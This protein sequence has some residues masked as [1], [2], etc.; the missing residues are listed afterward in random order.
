MTKK[1]SESKTNKSK[2]PKGKIAVT[3]GIADNEFKV[4][5]DKNM[6]A[7]FNVILACE[8]F[9]EGAIIEFYGAEGVGKTATVMKLAGDLQSQGE[10][11]GHVDAEHALN[12]KFARKNCGVDTKSILVSQKPIDC[13]ETAFELA[14]QFIKENGAD[15][16]VLDSIAACK[17]REFMEG[18]KDRIGAHAVLCSKYFPRL[19]TATAGGDAVLFT[20][21]QIRENIGQMFGDTKTTTGGNAPKFYSS[22][23]I[24]VT[25]KGK[26]KGEDGEEIGY[27]VTYEPT[28]NRFGYKRGR[29]EITMSRGFIPNVTETAINWA[30][31]Y[32]LV[33]A[34]NGTIAGLPVEGS[35]RLSKNLIKAV[36][37]QEKV[38]FDAVNDHFAQQEDAGLL[39]KD[40]M[41]KDLSDEAI[42]ADSGEQ[43]DVVLSAEEAE[44]LKEQSDEEV[45]E[46]DAKPAKKKATKK[47]ASSKKK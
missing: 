44:A 45:I 4:L 39:T 22:I 28:K 3:T 43:V 17:P 41:D 19:A 35:P 18:D 8:G 36:K 46:A 23:R 25:Q 24:K 16:V 31:E 7:M 9:P 11:Y 27:I 37:G 42:A 5:S 26:V 21:N 13:G 32:G 38:V 29:F 14:E 15:V 12:A 20:I 33:D 34:E 10:T 30:K 6:Q 47:K 1:V 40:E 2:A